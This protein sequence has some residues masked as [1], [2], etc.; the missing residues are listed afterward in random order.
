MKRASIARRAERRQS[1]SAQPTLPHVHTGARLG[2]E[3]RVAAISV[4]YDEK[5]WSDLTTRDHVKAMAELGA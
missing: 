3:Q 2:Y 5:I 4:I 1:L